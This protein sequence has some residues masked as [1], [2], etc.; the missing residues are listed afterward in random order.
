MNLN[1]VS[2]SPT[3]HLLA[4]L[5][6]PS[7]LKRIGSI[8][9]GVLAIGAAYTLYRSISSHFKLSQEVKELKAQNSQ[10]NEELAKALGRIQELET[11]K[12]KELHSAFNVAG[13]PFKCAHHVVVM[14]NPLKDENIFYTSLTAAGISPEFLNFLNTS[15]N[16]I[17]LWTPQ[18]K[19]ILM[20]LTR[21][22]VSALELKKCDSI[23]VIGPVKEWTSLHLRKKKE[24]NWIDLDKEQDLQKFIQTLKKSNFLS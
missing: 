12:P 4:P 7:A 24:V 3:Q 11:P 21:A 6:S 1:P 13:L 22:D 15:N 2:S 19:P 20:I 18:N 17:N 10:L 14:D 23:W 9:L 16:P 8:A 5:S